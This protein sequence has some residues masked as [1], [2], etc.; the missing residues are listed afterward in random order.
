MTL[1]L[2]VLQIHA[3]A[4]NLPLSL[5]NVIAKRKKNTV[6]KKSESIKCKSL[7][8]A[9]VDFFVMKARFSNCTTRLLKHVNFLR[10]WER[11]LHYRTTK[12]NKMQSSCHVDTDH[13]RLENK[14]KK[15]I[16]APYSHPSFGLAI[17]TSWDKYIHTLNVF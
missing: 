1:Q 11:H 4:I 8:R 16:Q 6:G 13:Y 17:S 2:V 7:K 14:Q 15:V 12:N 3:P 10:P 9:S 5:L